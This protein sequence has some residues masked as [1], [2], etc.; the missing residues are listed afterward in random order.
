VDK[1]DERAAMAYWWESRRDER[2]W[3]E[4]RKVPGHGLY[5]AAPLLQDHGRRDGR[6]ELVSAVRVGDIVYH[7]H[8][9]Q[10]RFIGRSVVAAPPTIK[11]D[12][13]YVELRGFTPIRVEVGLEDLRS[14]RRAIDD[15]KNRLE[16][17]YP[18]HTL[19][20]PFQFRTDG[21]LWMLSNYF[22]KLPTEIVEILFGQTGLGED[23][24]LPPLPDEGPDEPANSGSLRR[25][26]LQPF[27]PK[28]DEDYLVNIQ[29]GVRR[30]GRHHETLVNSFSTWLERRGFEVGCNAAIDIGIEDP[31]VV[32]EAKMVK[33]WS[34]N[35][36]EAVG[37]LYEYR[38]FRVADPEAQLIFLASEP[39]PDDWVAYL[40]RDR[41]IGVAWRVGGKFALSTLASR[42]LGSRSGSRIG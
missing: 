29:G 14:S 26:F 9:N 33:T 17:Q 1:D 39:V 35:I 4:I 20:L 42:M 36:R 10:H 11:D 28:A 12:E 25:S 16:D 40:E 6:Y 32:V 8:A 23:E 22:G 27:K 5:L 41:G 38:Y 30:R 18:D 3:V 31:P 15:V 34:T 7:W 37:Q 24:A 21:Q 19:Y 13:R 2:Y